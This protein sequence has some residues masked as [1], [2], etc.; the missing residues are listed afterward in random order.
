MNKKIAP[1]D[2]SANIGNA[3]KGTSGTNRQYDQAQG[4]RGKQ[5]AESQNSTPAVKHQDT[6][7]GGAKGG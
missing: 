1:K 4:N 5:L 7:K 6:T 3:N 2:N